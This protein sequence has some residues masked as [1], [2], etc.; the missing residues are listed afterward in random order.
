MAQKYRGIEKMY[1]SMNW[2][3]DFVNL[4]GISTEELVKR[5]NLATAE[6]E[7]YEEKGKDTYGVVFGKIIECE[8]HPESNH[9]H[10]LK[11][12]VKNE[13]LQIVCGAPNVRVGMVTCVAT[14]GGAVCGM[15]IK[16]AKL[17]GVESF[18]MCCSSAEL[19]IG[20]D[21]DGIMDITENVP[22]GEDIKNVW[23]IDDV[24]LEID[25][26]T[27]TNRPDL[28]GHYGLAREFSAIFG[29][30]LKPLKTIDLSKFDGL[31]KLD[32]ENQNPDCYRYGA[33]AVDNVTVKKSPMQ[34]AIRLTYA[35]MRDINL[36]AD[37]TNYIMLELG[38]P[39][40]AFDHDVVAG[41][42][43]L[44]ANEG[45]KILTLEG[46]EHEIP[47]GAIVIADNK[48]VPVAIAGI[49]GGLKASISDAT[50][51]V[52]FESAN[53]DPVMIRKTAR[54]IGLVTDASQRYEKSLDPELT[55]VALGR[56]LEVLKNIDKNIVVSSCFTDVYTKHYEK[57]SVEITSEFI[58]R[59]IGMQISDEQI[60]SV[61]TSLGFD[62]CKNGK[63]IIA[64]VPTYRATKDISM[65]EDIVEEVARMYG[66]DNI[67]PEPLSFNP[68]P[69]ELN[70]QVKEEY[71]VKKLLATKYNAIET[72]SHIWN[73]ADFNKSHFIN[74]ESVVKL[75]DSSNAGQS[76]IRAD[77]TP[78][79][80]KFVS[81]NRNNFSDIRI[82]EVGRVAPALDE[83]KLVKEEKRLS[84][85]FASQVQSVETLFDDLKCFIVDY[86]KNNL[87]LDVWLKD[88]EVPNFMHPYNSFRIVSRED[89]FGF[90]GVL[91][92]K[93]SNAIDKR[94]NIVAL[95]VDFGKLAS[96]HGFFKKAKVPAKFQSV[97]LDISVGVPTQMRYG[98]LEQILN[99]YRSKI[100][101]GYILKDIYEGEALQSGRKNI[102][103]TYELSG[104]DHTLAGSEI[105][106]FLNN[107]IAH[108]EKNKLVVK[109]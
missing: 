97:K 26:K 100:S 106:E 57:K 92:P 50:T 33:I 101:N 32:I 19:G 48:K 93:V 88:G 80:L 51:N 25:N 16:P 62:V 96:K 102:T 91:N 60:V 104:K 75:L 12:D 46:E 72:H 64:K 94:L 21:D 39:M 6:I 43:V 30:E 84:V 27:L 58:S 71:E 59:R 90:V 54:A 15:K 37:I 70:V 103:I 78:T 87:Q 35:G 31:E 69:V 1:I 45:D 24:V 22:L 40:H 95:E 18:G 5:F 14:V 105:D 55:S 17:V 23:P 79:M 53:F 85:V 3:K 38:Q 11:V 44:K 67:I 98:E 20:S 66:Y 2:I 86:A 83:N 61:L 52:L 9:L 65:K 107:L 4:D 99:K 36:L 74:S 42:K 77:L 41:I 76:G 10:I 7:G 109:R 108:L 73:F 34:M 68:A 47:S 82:F 28:W 81:E 49:K 56:I 13:I 8:N 29:R 89:D 63:T